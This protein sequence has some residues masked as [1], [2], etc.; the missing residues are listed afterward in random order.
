MPSKTRKPAPLVAAA[1]PAALPTAGVGA[2]A[3]GSG[4][5]LAILRR[6]G[7]R[8]GMA[9]LFILH[10]EKKHESLL[11]EVV[12][13]ATKMP[14]IAATDGARIECN[15]VYVVPPAVEVTITN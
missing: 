14:V 7:D 2:P 5:F 1:V 9:L 8:P 15:H 3:G 10:Q 11:V 6:L 4:P 12:S 13:R